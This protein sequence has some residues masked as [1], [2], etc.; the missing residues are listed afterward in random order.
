MT[1]TRI[2]TFLSVFWIGFIPAFSQKTAPL[3]GS[4]IWVEPGHTEA[5]IS[6]WFKTLADNKMPV[7][8]LFIMWN[9]MEKEQGV[10]DYKIY[11]WAFKAAEKHNVKIVATLMPN[12]GPPSRG[13]VYKIQDGAIAKS[14]RQWE[15]SKVYIKNIVTR[16]SKSSALDSWMMMN[17]PGQFP[18]PDSLALDRF[19][20]WLENKYKGD[21]K[22]LNTA[23]LSNFNSFKTISYSENWS[24]GGWTWPTP[25]VDWQMF[26]REHLGWYLSMVTSEIR[27]YDN[28]HGF[29]INP[30][31]LLDITSKYDFPAWK[32]FL[33][34]LG[35]SIHPVWHFD[36][37]KREQFPLG[38]SFV[39]DMIRGSVS[40]MPFWVTELQG[41]H[42]MYTGSRGIVPER[43][44]TARW[45]WTSIVSGAERVVYWCLNARGQGTE[46][47]EWSLLNYD[48][49]AS[50]RLEVSKEI[51]EIVEKNK[52]AF[53]A[54]TP[55]LPKV[56]VLMS[57][58]TMVLQERWKANEKDSPARNP[59]AHKEA[60]FGVYKSLSE[61]GIAPQIE[62]L[63]D[64][65]FQPEPKGET[66]IL[67]HATSLTNEQ[68]AKL[69]DF[70]TRGG[71]LIIT[72]LTGVVNEVEASRLLIEDPFHQLVKGRI[73]AVGIADR[74]QLLSIGGFQMPIT[75]F[76]AEV[77]APKAGKIIATYGDKTMGYKVS[78]GKGV[79]VYVPS[80]IDIGNWNSKE[81][82]LGKWLISEL[83]SPNNL[84]L[85][86]PVENGLVKTARLATG[87]QMFVVCNSAQATQK[88]VFETGIIANKI[89]WLYQKGA[90]FNAQ[91][92]SITVNGGGVAVFV[93]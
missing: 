75:H 26:W 85:K 43:E 74:A 25:Y 14:M 34:S 84:K 80:C 91:E 32:P 19:K 49:T 42:N 81:G 18:S 16:Y 13:F 88:F 57:T 7:C 50:D 67:P 71:K 24:G 22:A 70:V 69:N 3:I 11:D 62:N 52:T 90:N 23:W 28:S 44:E 45:V 92:K 17:E 37:L 35:A 63:D 61:W 46:V 5:Q 60:V 87:K 1:K 64:W 4:Q 93:Q 15:E 55:E 40:P 33:T 51:A 77:I 53:A 66:V 59:K 27:K 78:S 39:C 9:F 76:S 6:G 12:F 29:H 83:A 21:I 58:Q 89:E 56:T 68:I 79:V 54:I 8:R 30:H 38:V 65:A 41:G 36:M 20:P 86:S 2:L 82:D 31:G 48:G 73:K 47:S 72:G 10:W